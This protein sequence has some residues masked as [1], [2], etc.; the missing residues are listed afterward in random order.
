M[1]LV[2]R[3]SRK[4][5]YNLCLQCPHKR[6]TRPRALLANPVATLPTGT[7]TSRWID[8]SAYENIFQPNHA[9]NVRIGQ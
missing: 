7:V 5:P 1:D 4:T 8:V 2:S 3:G 6:L 9:A